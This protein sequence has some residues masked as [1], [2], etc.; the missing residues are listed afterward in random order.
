LSDLFGGE[1]RRFMRQQELLKPF[2]IS[3]YL[4]KAHRPITDAFKGQTT[5]FRAAAELVDGVDLNSAAAVFDPLKAV[6]VFNFTVF[7]GAPEQPGV[8]RA[9]EDVGRA[10]DVLL[11]WW[12]DTPQQ[13]LANLGQQCRCVLQEQLAPQ[14]PDGPLQ[15]C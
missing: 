11:G 15:R 10:V 12:P 4:F 8:S 13:Q 7:S 1:L 6:G 2:P 3:G 14:C 5:V 9:V